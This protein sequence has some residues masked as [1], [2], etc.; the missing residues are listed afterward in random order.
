MNYSACIGEFEQLYMA[1]ASV[2]MLLAIISSIVLLRNG[3][4]EDKKA[5]I[6]EDTLLGP[7]FWFISGKTLNNKGKRWRPVLIT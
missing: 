3:S 6:I 5:Q 7:F 2:L 4:D 1:I